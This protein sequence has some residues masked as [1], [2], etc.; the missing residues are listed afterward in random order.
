MEGQPQLRR[1]QVDSRAGEER[2]T[3]G[4]W[5]FPGCEVEGGR[6]VGQVEGGEVGRGCPC[7]WRGVCIMHRWPL[8]GLGLRAQGESGRMVALRIQKAG[9]PRFASSSFVLS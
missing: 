4:A 7:P 1:G 9:L 3:D 8:A 6:D 5:G 2:V